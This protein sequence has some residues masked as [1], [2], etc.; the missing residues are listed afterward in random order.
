MLRSENGQL[1]FYMNIDGVLR[2]IRVPNVLTTGEWQHIAGTYDGQTMRLYRNGILLDSLE[3]AGSLDDSSTVNINS[4][5]EPFD[6]KLDEVTLYN[7]ALTGSEVYDLAQSQLAKI[8]GLDYSAELLGNGSVLNNLPLPSD[9]LLYLP[10]EDIHSDVVTDTSLPLP[11][12][13]AQT[14]ASPAVGQPAP[15]PA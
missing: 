2:H 4:A 6:G 7:R 1:H 8:A 15:L 5:G 11:I 13:L 12:S 9:A 10:L 3:I 14:T